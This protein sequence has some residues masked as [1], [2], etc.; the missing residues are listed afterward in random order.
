MSPFGAKF[1]RNRPFVKLIIL[2][3]LTCCSLAEQYE[4]YQNYDYTTLRANLK[5]LQVRF[6]DIVRLD[7]AA[8]KFGIDYIVKCGEAI[9]EDEADDNDLMGNDCVLDIV[10]VTDH[11]IGPEDKI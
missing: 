5:K 3:M 1:E 9:N 8:N 4:Y 6:P 10:T 11:L 7:T 2:L